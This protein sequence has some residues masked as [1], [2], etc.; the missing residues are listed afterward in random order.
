MF[1]FIFELGYYS[2]EESPIVPVHAAFSRL[3]LATLLLSVLIFLY[4]AYLYLAVAR[5]WSNVL[6]RDKLYA[7]FNLF[8]ILLNLAFTSLGWLSFY[9]E[10]SQKFEIFYA[11]MNFYIIYLQYMYS[12]P[13]GKPAA[14][15]SKLQQ[16]ED[17]TEAV[18][19]SKDGG[20]CIT[21]NLEDY[22]KEFVSDLPQK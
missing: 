18:E 3:Y 8:F 9:E 2:Y 4:I 19:N 14:G 1:F 13:F 11:S 5:E 22:P 12:T 20:N 7:A 21:I 15:D 6:W 10:S 17:N 16:V